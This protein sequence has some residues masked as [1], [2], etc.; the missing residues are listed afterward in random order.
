M[1]IFAKH[2]LAIARRLVAEDDAKKPIPLPKD[3]HSSPALQEMGVWYESDDFDNNAYDLLLSKFFNA[4]DAKDFQVKSLGE[5]NGWPMFMATRYREKTRGPNVLVVSGF[6][7]EEQAGPWGVLRYLEIVPN[8]VL[9]RVN[10]SLIPVVNPTGFREGRRG[11]DYGE[12]A[13]N[14]GFR[15]EV[16]DSDR[17]AEGRILMSHL[18]ELRHLAADGFLSLHEDGEED[19]FYMYAMEDGGPSDLT[20]ILLA[21]GVQHFGMLKDKKIS[22]PGGGKTKDGLILNYHDGCFEDRLAA[23]GC[24]HCY[25]TETPMSAKIEDRIRAG[26][27]LIDVLVKKVAEGGPKKI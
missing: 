21:V 20:N 6:H 5:V 3:I 26:V 23:E 19:E 25:A 1:K 17:S 22:A 2:L 13:T 14:G 9:S 7:G 10:L 16:E 12:E 18:D 15:P 27:A 4:A 11:N 24:A 8:E